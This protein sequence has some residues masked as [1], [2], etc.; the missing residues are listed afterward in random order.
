MVG[1]AVVGETQ[2]IFHWK[3]YPYP[4][5]KERPAAQHDSEGVLW[6]PQ[7]VFRRDGFTL[8]VWTATLTIWLQP[9]AEKGI[10]QV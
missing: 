8:T 10:V 7:P 3:E 5:A 1:T 2:Q 6:L 4:E 9:K